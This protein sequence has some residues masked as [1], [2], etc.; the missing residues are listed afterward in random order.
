MKVKRKL[1]EI[2]SKKHFNL[3]AQNAVKQEFQ[4]DS[5]KGRCGKIF[6]YRKE[7]NE[8]V[9]MN[10]QVLKCLVWTILNKNRQCFL[11]KAI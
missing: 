3:H 5:L 4:I 8:N 2:F 10:I 11:G 1:M 6:L 7:K 9:A